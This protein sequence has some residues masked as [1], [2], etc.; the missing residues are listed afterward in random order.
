[1]PSIYSI[2][3]GITVALGIALAG[4]GYW[5]SNVIADRAT[6]RAAFNAAV[7][8]NASLVTEAKKLAAQAEA[9]SLRA[10][11]RQ[12]ERDGMAEQ[13]IELRRVLGDDPCAWTPEKDAALQKFMGGIR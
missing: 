4:T 5:L 3:I 11:A 2:I 9:E 13:V 1:M 10:Q 6:V 8:A 7:E 12:R